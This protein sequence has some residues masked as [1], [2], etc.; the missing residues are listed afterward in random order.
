MQQLLGAI[1]A[2]IAVLLVL[3]P[4]VILGQRLFAGSATANAINELETIASQTLSVFPNGNF[5]GLN[6]AIAEQT[7]IIPQNM[8]A[9]AVGAGNDIDPW[10]GAV[11]V[12]VDSGSQAL[13]DITFTMVPKDACVKMAQWT[14]S[15]LNGVLVNNALLNPPI[16]VT[17]AV[18]ACG[19]PNNNTLQFRLSQGG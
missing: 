16:D 7:G 12:A 8:I 4:A 17:S 13:F 19:S 15:S 14:S 11:T 9:G 2:I 1:V 18:T 6:N 10:G 5:T 3:I